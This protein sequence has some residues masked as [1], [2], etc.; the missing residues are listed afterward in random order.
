MNVHSTCVHNN[1]KTRSPRHVEYW[2]EKLIEAHP[3]YEIL[4]VDKMEQNS[5]RQNIQSDYYKQ[6]V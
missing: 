6:A 1:T 5:D 2:T 3:Y 4:T